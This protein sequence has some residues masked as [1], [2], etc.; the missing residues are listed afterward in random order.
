MY[1]FSWFWSFLN[2]E[3]ALAMRVMIHT[4]KCLKCNWHVK[5]II[6]FQFY[7]FIVSSSLISNYIWFLQLLLLLV[8]PFLLLF[9]PPPILLHHLL[10]HP[11]FSFS[12]FFFIT[13]KALGLWACCNR[14]NLTPDQ[15]P[16]RNQLN[17][18]KLQCS[19]DFVCSYCVFCR[20]CRVTISGQPSNQNYRIIGHQW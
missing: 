14:Y 17:V 8:L 5:K 9:S 15:P 16:F 3:L 13:Y 11:P 20:W 6:S 1:R 18:S 12:F 10:L 19:R 7:I 2:Q 4:G